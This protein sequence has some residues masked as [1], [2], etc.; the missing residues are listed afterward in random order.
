[1]TEKK[2]S[3][4][5]PLYNAEAFIAESINSLLKQTYPNI[6]LIIVDDG[7]SDNSFDVAKKFESEN[8]RVFQQNN[9]GAC[10]ARN[11][12]FELSTGDYINFFDADDLMSTK[13]IENQMQLVNKYGDDYIYSSQW[14]PFIENPGDIEKQPNLIDQSFENVCDWLRTSWTNNLSA[15][16]GIWLTP[17]KI[18]ESVGGWDESLKVN[19]DGDFFFRALLKS[20]Q[21]KFA[22]NA[23]VYYRREL[24]GSISNTNIPERAESILKSYKKYE[25]VLKIDDSYEMKKAL[26]YNYIRFIYTF[27]PSY[28]Y[29]ITKARDYIDNLGVNEKWN[30]G[31]EKFKKLSNLIGFFNALKLRK[32][33]K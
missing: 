15:Q 17:R 4:L 8:V 22:K 26:A 27:Y 30:V 2:V 9:K 1:M 10:A 12:A 14:I 33:V 16:T 3:I 24:S 18:V 32:V 11:K 21:V 5:I 6:E 29:L 25:E 7:S 23:L 31:G 28:P 13:K 20:K 19:Q